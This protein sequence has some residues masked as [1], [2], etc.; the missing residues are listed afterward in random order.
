MVCSIFWEEFYKTLPIKFFILYK[1]IH[2]KY[3]EAA[4]NVNQLK[5]VERIVRDKKDC[6]DPI[7][8]KDFLK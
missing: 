2:Y 3:I 8:V 6:Y 5:E 7:K 4:V 1:E